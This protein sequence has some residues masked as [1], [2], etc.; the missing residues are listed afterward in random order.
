[1]DYKT[2]K[3]V[4]ENLKNEMTD[5]TKIIVAQRVGTIM[6]ADQIIVL[7]EGKIVGIGKHQELLNTCSVYLEIALSQLTKEELGLC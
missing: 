1:M 6:D 7:D 3:K 5:A 2:D 4:R